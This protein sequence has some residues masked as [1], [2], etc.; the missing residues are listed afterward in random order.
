MRAQLSNI[1][2]SLR[3]MNKFEF[4]LS[5]GKLGSSSARKIFIE[6]KL[7]SSFL[8]TLTNEPGYSEARLNSA[9]L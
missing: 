6:L 4:N 8:T 5:L 3:L 7:G 2:D 1:F 9:N